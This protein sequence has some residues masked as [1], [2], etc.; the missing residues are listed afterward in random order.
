MLLVLCA[1]YSLSFSSPP[2]AR[3]VNQ[4]FSQPVSQSANQPIKHSRCS[5]SVG[6]HIFFLSSGT[7]SVYVNDTNVATLHPGACFGEI[8]VLIPNS[9]R[10]ATI[11]AQ[12]FSEAQML[13]RNDFFECLTEFPSLKEQA[14][15]SSVNHP[16][17]HP[18]LRPIS[19]YC[20]LPSDLSP[21]T[22]SSPPACLGSAGSAGGQ[23]ARAGHDSSA[24]GALDTAARRGGTPNPRTATPNPRTA[25]PNPCTATPI[26]ARPP[27]I[28]ARRP[29]CEASAGRMSR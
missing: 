3:P 11:V 6:S 9:R 14:I 13:S 16:S 28:P 25:T 10:A 2:L 1:C 20:L 8:A 22:A 12:T 29:A 24:R 18:P 19:P 27:P 5:V 15:T 4:S 7:L 26:P 21:L 17:L 23:E